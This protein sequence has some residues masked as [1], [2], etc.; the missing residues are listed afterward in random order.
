M[1]ILKSKGEKD[2]GYQVSVSKIFPVSPD[3]MWAFI[4]SQEGIELYLG[5]MDLEDFELQKPFVS[6]AGLE[7]KLTVFV[8][9]CHLRFKWKPSNWERF[10][11]VELRITNSKGRAAVLFYHAGF[12]KQQQVEEL[13]AHWKNVIADMLLKLC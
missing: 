9:D 7:G 12:Y 13:R 10:S 8:P 4:L 6:K 11:T 2:L 1:N 3:A 5:E